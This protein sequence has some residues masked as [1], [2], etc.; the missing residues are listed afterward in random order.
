VCCPTSSPRRPSFM[1]V[2]RV[3]PEIASRAHLE[4]M[5]P[6]IEQ[7]LSRRGEAVRH[8]RIAVAHRRIDGSLLIGV[9]AAKTL[10]WAL[11]SRWSASI[12]FRRI[13]T[14]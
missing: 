6:V 13:C 10:A 4:N 1:Q 8:R 9:T 7:A 2:S 5:L 3:V 14:A 11:D 12:T